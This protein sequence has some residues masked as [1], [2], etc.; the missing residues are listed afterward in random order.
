MPM[1]G[2]AQMKWMTMMMKTMAKVMMNDMNDG[3]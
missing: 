1:T 3:K 2:K